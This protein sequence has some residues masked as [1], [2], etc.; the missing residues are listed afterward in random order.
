MKKSDETFSENCLNI[1]Q[2]LIKSSFDKLTG[3]E[4][5]VVKEHLKSCGRCRIFQ[6]TLV[7]LH[8]SA[9]I[10]LKG[11]LAPDS[12]IHRN[13]IKRMKT[14]RPQK[15]RVFG[16]IWKYIRNIL[17]YRIPVYQ[18]AF[19]AALILLL[20]FTVDQISVLPANKVPD[21]HNILQT[22][23]SISTQMNVVD[24]LNIIEHQK[25]GRSVREDSILTRYIVTM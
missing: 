25:I 10:P 7:N 24:D 22:E 3:D 4:N 5:L 19:G 15:Q 8:E 6:N 20:I 23:E 9:A 17:E 11:K 12:A 13:I 21:S 1:E 14:A 18:A 2:L 16:K